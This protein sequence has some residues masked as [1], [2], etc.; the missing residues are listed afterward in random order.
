M[1]FEKLKARFNR[2]EDPPI[3][4]RTD[5]SVSW[6]NRSRV[7]IVLSVIVV[8]VLICLVVGFFW[9][10]EPDLFNVE[11]NKQQI[12]AD[13]GLNDVIGT[14]TTS[15]LIKVASTLLDKPG[16]YLSNDIFLPGVWLDNIP[17]WEFGVLVQLRDMSKVMRESF[18]RSQSQSIEDEDLIVAE[19]G[20]NFPNNSWILPPSEG[21]YRNAIEALESYLAR[22][23][24]PQNQQAQFYSRADN[25]NSWLMNVETRLGSLSQRLSSSVA[26]RRVNTDLAGDANSAQSTPVASEV[27]VKTPWLEIDDVFYE[28]RGAA[29]AL[30]HFLRAIQVDFHDVLE[31]KNAVI[32][33]EQII[34]E[35]EASQRFVFSPMILN[36]SGFGLLANHSL[37][38]A[39]YISRANA[40]IIDLRSLLAQG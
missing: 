21:Q 27:V 38:M 26:Q 1:V 18:S 36:G 30:V 34:R 17:N 32:S 14:A 2:S 22:L 10:F 25:L 13:R 29:W 3:A 11:Q 7:K 6:I 40:A 28:A 31:D 8:Y 23:A 35:L 16:G 20:F 12:L 4:I 33:V 37:V 39:S 15:T 19:P 9:S 24:D 5:L